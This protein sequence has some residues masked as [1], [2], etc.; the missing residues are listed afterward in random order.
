MV[1]IHRV[2]KTFEVVLV[3]GVTIGNYFMDIG[4]EYL[5]EVKNYINDTNQPDWFLEFQ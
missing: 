4:K 5:E 3:G 1:Q 2:L